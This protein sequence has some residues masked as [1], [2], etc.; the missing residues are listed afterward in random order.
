MR[1]VAATPYN[2]VWLR[3]H[4]SPPTSKEQCDV[5]RQSD[6]IIG[7]TVYRGGYCAKIGGLLVSFPRTGRKKGDIILKKGKPVVI[8]MQ[9]YTPPP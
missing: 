3:L 6:Q 8:V 7:G 4:G 9:S 1:R 5:R 2:Q